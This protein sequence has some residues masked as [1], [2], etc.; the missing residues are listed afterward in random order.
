MKIL[1]NMKMSEGG[2]LDDHLNEFH[3]VTNKLRFVNVNFDDEVRPLL[4]ICSLPKRWNG[5]VMVVSNS[6]FG[7]NTL[8]FDDVIGVILNK[9]MR[10]KI[11]GETSG[12]ALTVENRG[13]QKE[14]GKS[15]GNHG[16]SWKGKSKSRLGKTKCWNCGKKGHLKK[17]RRDPKKQGDGH[18][19]KNQ[20]TNVAGDVLQDALFISLD[21]I[22]ES[23]VVDSGASFHATPHKKYF[24]DSCSK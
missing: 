3:M 4:I 1:F 12:N 10:R 23:W 8:K 16:N 7:A 15:R 11:I 19:E 6:V 21:N 13:R 24:Q 2:S 9:E 22:T 20:E 17:D 5:L 18:Q 14:S